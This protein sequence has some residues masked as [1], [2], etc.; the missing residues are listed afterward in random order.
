MD[1]RW[2]DHTTLASDIIASVVP[3]SRE[4]VAPCARAL[5]TYNFKDTGRVSLQNTRVVILAGL[6]RPKTPITDT[7]VDGVFCTTGCKPHWLRVSTLW[8]P[9]MLVQCN[10]LGVVLQLLKSAD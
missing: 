5:I 9:V 10:L 1:Q 6:G 3:G 8:G 4:R 7:L 2:K